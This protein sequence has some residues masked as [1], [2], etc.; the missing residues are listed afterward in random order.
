MEEQGILPV[1]ETCGHGITPH[2][3][4]HGFGR[5]MIG[6][7]EDCTACKDRRNQ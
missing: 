3:P 5:I 4:D 7:C 1:C 6:D 2:N